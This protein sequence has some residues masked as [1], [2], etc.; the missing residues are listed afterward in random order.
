MELFD[1]T[2][3]RRCVWLRC[4][5]LFLQIGHHPKVNNNRKRDHQ[6]TSKYGCRQKLKNAIH[7]FYTS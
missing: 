5:N 1:T 2:K 7:S 3:E 4:P 6:F